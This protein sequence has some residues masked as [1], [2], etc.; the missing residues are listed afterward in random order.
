MHVTSTTRARIET[1]GGGVVAHVGLHALGRFADAVGLGAALSAR[2]VAAGE[3]FPL[4]D[5]GKVLV[6]AMLTLAG[7]GDACSDVEFLRAQPA[8]FGPVSSDSTLYRTY[9]QIDAATLAGLWDAMAEVRSD[10]WSVVDTGEPV[11]LDIDASLVEIH[12]EHKQGT[13]PTYKRGFGFHPMFCFADFTGE[14]LAAL[15]RPGNATANNAADHLCVLD[16]AIGQLPAE[17]ASGHRDGDDPAGVAR[18]VM[19]RAD[20]AGATRGF[21]WGCRA[22]NVGFAVVARKTT[23]IHGAIS[24]IELDDDRWAPAFTQAGDQRCDAA[25]CEVTDLVD[26]SHW[27]QGTRLIVRREPLHPGAQQTLFPSLQFRYWGHYTDQHGDPVT[28][29]QHMRAHAHVEDHIRRLKDS[30][31]ERFPFVD[32]DANR[33]RLAI[34]AFAADL[35]RWFQLCCLDGPLA[36]AEPKMLRWQ[37]W[38]TPARLV[39]RA[40]QQIVRILDDWP[41]TDV[42]LRAYTRVALLT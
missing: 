10:V 22:R 20:S 28:L 12:S 42:L 26:L 8:L 1:G 36:I 39:R 14:T 27:P 4:H 34:V 13:A 7:G 19:V 30:G 17:I 11:V 23:Q 3:R 24:K 18:P 32:L 41:T 37:L 2:I 35:V 15:L 9:R 21:V 29:D 25:V 38:H 6:H 5:R 33:A 31:L 40:R 16:H